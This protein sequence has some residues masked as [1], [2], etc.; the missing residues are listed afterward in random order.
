[1]ETV[2]FCAMLAV[3]M[4]TTGVFLIIF[5]NKVKEDGKKNLTQIIIGWVTLAVSVL[6]LIVSFIVYLYLAGGISGAYLF[7]FIS[8][9][10]ILAGFIVMLALGISS[11][12]E[13]FK[14]DKDGRR[15]PSAMVRGWTRSTTATQTTW[16][17]RLETMRSCSA[18]LLPTRICRNSPSQ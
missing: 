13:G 11:L 5:G 3:I 15:N 9:L 8:P 4:L 7:I 1:M 17:K 12:V 18:A 2:F 6:I 14:K 10:F 16:P